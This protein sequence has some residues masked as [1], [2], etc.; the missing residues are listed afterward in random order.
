MAYTAK[1]ISR[2][3]L[4]DIVF[5]DAPAQRRAAAFAEAS[6]INCLYMIQNAGSGHIGTSFS[7]LE[8]MSW[9]HMEEMDENDFFFSSKGHDAPALYT[10]L[11]GLGRLPFEK[12][13]QLRRLGGL[14][15][16]PDV[17]TECMVTNTGSLGMGIAKARGM[18]KARRLDGRPGRAFVLLGDG[19][20]EEG[21]IWESLQPTAN[22][23][24]SELTVIV[25]HNKI[26]SDTWVSDTSDL[27]DLE[28]KFRAFGWEVVRCD[29]ND[30][31]ALSGALAY[32]R[33]VEAR[34]KML[35][36]DTIKGR[37]VSFMER[38]DAEATGGLYAYHSG[39]V[40]PEVYAKALAELTANLTTACAEAGIPMPAFTEAEITPATPLE[41]PQK[42]VAAYGRKLLELGGEREDMVVLDADLVL[43]CGLLG[44]RDAFPDRFVECGIAEQ[45][46][47]SMAGGLA[48]SGK[49]PL[50]HSFGCFLTTRPG[51]QIFNNATEKTKIIYAGSLVGI[52]PGG[53][54]H[55]HQSVRD[56]AL[57]SCV[58]GMTCVE[59]CCEAETE[60]ALEWAV[61]A[62]P[63]STYIRLVSIPCPKSFELPAGYRLTP[64]KGA[65]LREGKA[66]APLVFAYGPV[67]TEQACRAADQ[68]AAQGIDAT[69]VNLPWLS[70]VDEQWLREI[71]GT[72]D[73]VLTLDNHLL[74]GGQGEMLAATAARLGLG[75][76][77]HCLGLT[78]KP[79]CG[80]NDEVLAHHG[81]D[82]NGIAG[83][84]RAIVA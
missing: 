54:G 80:R 66:D 38:F 18:I 63:G 32:L 64:G 24:Y 76:R 19:E 10:V 83:R 39:A 45:D 56:I 73:N 40:S 37:G 43:D 68:L 28:T 84:V 41:N 16:H 12:L 78:G 36:A 69:V 21:Q 62:N 20:L 9:L 82:A 22:G 57:M 7:S 49:L 71:V 14:P 81:L 58:P 31:D 77:F 53:P 29:G 26:Q 13:H 47:V 4:A 51:E 61:Q 15:G 48:L 25:D 17:G 42:L 2:E 8:I 3:A 1:Y 74:K 67:L 70:G 27:G 75:A 44:F 35:I 30:V 72:R 5:A 46:M 50:V 55:S 59:P 60:M 6:R 11:L 23:E 52:L 79:A 34:P 65:V 33:G